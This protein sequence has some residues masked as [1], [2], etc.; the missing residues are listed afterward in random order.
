ME[1]RVSDALESTRPALIWIAGAVVLVVWVLPDLA[2]L[3][4]YAVLLA[5]A[6]LPLVGALERVRLG[7]ARPISRGVASAIVMLALVVLAGLALV[8]TLPRLAAEAA[9]FATR[10]PASGTR[11]IEEVRAWAE[12]RGL[13]PSLDPVIEGV[14]ANTSGLLQ[15]L[16]GAIVRGIG[17]L[18]GGLGQVLGLAILPLLAFY[19]LADADAVRASAL[20]F[21]PVEARRDIVRLGDAVDRALRSYVRGQALVCLVMALA[22]GVALA[23]VGFPLALLLGVLVGVAELIPYIGFAIA[24]IAVGL[25]GLSVSPFHALLG[26]LL[27]TGINW[28]IGTFVTPRVM[29]R[30]LKMHP[31]VITISVLAG[32]KLLGP[33][34]ALL[35]LPGAA[36]VQAIVSELA[37]REPHAR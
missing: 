5:Y 9:H 12:A 7:R 10:V 33:A 25:T 3:V 35:A 15:N 4:G 13:G 31:F 20:G 37:P 34:G 2:L 24:A 28:A 21:V 22:T 23:L 14:R 16:G 19:L 8:L 36:V 17:V 27:Y 26:V 18:F 29:G 30:Y 6:L 11:L 1:P 32:A